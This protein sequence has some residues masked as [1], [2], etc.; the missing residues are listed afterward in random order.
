MRLLSSLQDALAY[1]SVAAVMMA[2]YRLL[3]W[4]SHWLLP[5]AHMT[6]CGPGEKS[7]GYGTSSRELS[8]LRCCL[9]ADKLVEADDGV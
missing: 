5:R 9:A 3:P 6:W 4:W 8:L 2:R 7:G 1:F